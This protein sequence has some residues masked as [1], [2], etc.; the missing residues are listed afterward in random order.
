MLV[1]M[2]VKPDQYVVHGLNPPATSN[3]ISYPFISSLCMILY[4]IIHILCIL[5]VY[6]CILY[7]DQETPNGVEWSFQPLILKMICGQ[8]G[9]CLTCSSYRIGTWRC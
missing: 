9:A 7:S 6:I 8:T 1:V 5:Y 4:N 2:M 3:I